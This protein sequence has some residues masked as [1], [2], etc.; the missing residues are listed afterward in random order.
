MPLPALDFDPSEAAVSWQVLTAA[1]HRVVF[2]TPDGWMAQADSRMLTGEGLDLW[3]FVPGLRLVRLVGLVLRANAAARAAHAS[4]VQESAYRWPESYGQLEASSFDALILPGG[5]RARGMRA[6]LEDERLHL[7]VAA[8]FDADKPVAAICHGTVLAA[9]SQSTR[10][11]KSVLFGRRTTG[12]T[13][14]LERSA[15][16]TMKLFGRFW[17]AD[18]YRTYPELPGEPIGFRSVEAEVRR[19]L[20][21]PGDFLDVDRGAE[22]YFRKVSG[23]FRDS[24]K[25]DRP[26]WVVRDGKYLSARWPGDVHTF[27]RAFARILM[28][29]SA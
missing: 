15:W 10:T 27:A 11:G 2:A 4:M 14:Q 12:L 26:A 7:L 5:H 21:D 29:E 22:G 6:Y 1:G 23:L 16:L 20:A 17:D 8:F 18:Y 25:D 9:R 19:A 24:L 3:S 28:E 13:W